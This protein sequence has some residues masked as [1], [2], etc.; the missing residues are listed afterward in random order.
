MTF[1]G[2]NDTINPQL[3]RLAQGY[4]ES[5][6]RS[7]EENEERKTIRDNAEKLGIPSK[8]F[9]HAVSMV[10]LMSDG[11][12]RD[13]QAGIAAAL[14]AFGDQQTSLFPEEAERIKRR[15]ERKAKSRAEQDAQSDANPR[16]NPDNGGAAPTFDE[17]AEQ[18][19][20]E[21]VLSSLSAL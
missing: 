3:Q 10:K 18:E 19:E 9:Q 7:K 1:D 4:A 13:Y 2:T 5:L 12:R 16:S 17:T 8:S 11:E 20:G 6:R 14:A 15:E 21:A